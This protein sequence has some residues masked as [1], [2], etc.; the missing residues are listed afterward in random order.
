LGLVDASQG[1][2]GTPVDK[3][4]LFCFQYDPSTARYSATILT[5]MRLMAVATVAGLLLM[6]LIFRRRDKRAPQANLS[7]QGAD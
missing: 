5:V 7:H 6:I 3:M 2:I 4:L 1:K